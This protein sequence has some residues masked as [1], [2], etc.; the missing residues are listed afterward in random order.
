[1]LI[2]IHLQNLIKNS[3]KTGTAQVGTRLFKKITVFEIFGA[4]KT[5]MG[6]LETRTQLFMNRKLQ[7]NQNNKKYIF[8]HFCC[9]AKSQS[10]ENTREDPLKLQNAFAS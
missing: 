7:K 8:F 3:N 4:K 9:Q 6:T 5:R 2:P 10:S 1:M